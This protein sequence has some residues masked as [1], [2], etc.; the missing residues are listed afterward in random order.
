MLNNLNNYLSQFSHEFDNNANIENNLHCG[1]FPSDGKQ[2]HIWI[3]HCQGQIAQTSHNEF[4]NWS[5]VKS[6]QLLKRIQ[7]S[8]IITKIGLENGNIEALLSV[9]SNQFNFTTNLTK[10]VNINIGQKI[11]RKQTGKLSL[12]KPRF[13]LIFVTLWHCG[14]EI[15]KVQILDY[16]IYT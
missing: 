14:S 8:S 4:A 15:I 10:G 16:L 6:Q 13:Q 12:T 2:S 3:Q 11:Q 9:N 1:I 7:I 5:S